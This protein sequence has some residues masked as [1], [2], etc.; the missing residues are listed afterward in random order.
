MAFTKIPFPE[1]IYSSFKRVNTLIDDLASVLSGK[2]A[3]QIGICDSGNLFTATNVED[4]LAEL[5]GDLTTHKANTTN[6]HSVT[7]A[8]VG[9]GNVPDLDLSASQQLILPI[10]YSLYAGAFDGNIFF[11]YVLS[12]NQ[13]LSSP[14]LDLDTDTAVANWKLWTGAEFQNLTSTGFPSTYEALF[15]LWGSGERNINYYGYW[16]AY[17]GSQYGDKIPIIISL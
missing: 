1:T 14:V 3:S 13:D 12:K 4:V 17:Q 6:P 2:G 16:Q 15:Y 5:N 9:L 8:Q 10:P 7:K 11:K